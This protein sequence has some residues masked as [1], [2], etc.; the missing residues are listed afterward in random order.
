LEN[1]LHL[2]IKDIECFPRRAVAA[3]L[4]DWLQKHPSLQSQLL[5]LASADDNAIGAELQGAMC[6]H[7]WEVKIRMVEFWE[8]AAKLALKIDGSNCGEIAVKVL[9]VALHDCDRPVTHKAQEVLS[10]LKEITLSHKHT[11]KNSTL[12][13]RH[14]APKEVEKV[15]TMEITAGK[16][17]STEEFVLSVKENVEMNSQS[18]VNCGNTSTV[19]ETFRNTIF[20]NSNKLE[21]NTAFQD[22]HLKGIEDLDAEACGENLCNIAQ[23]AQHD[24]HGQA[25]PQYIS[26]SLQAILETLELPPEMEA[27][28]AAVALLQDILASAEKLQGDGADCY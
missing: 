2:L 27:T 1:L 10:S 23:S 18:N 3:L 5:I 17:S 13:T 12:S 9:L 19:P 25:K 26:S 11:S 24:G 14:C 16:S 28:D 15:E 6:D 20:D 22:S 21:S 7:D 4:T 8:V